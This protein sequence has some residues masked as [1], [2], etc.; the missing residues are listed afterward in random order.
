MEPW[1]G[2]FKSPHGP[3][4]SSFL[5]RSCID[6]MIFRLCCGPGQWK[7]LFVVIWSSISVCVQQHVEVYCFNLRNVIWQN[8]KN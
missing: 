7:T 4:L 2:S 1:R 3:A 8:A 5:L 6:G